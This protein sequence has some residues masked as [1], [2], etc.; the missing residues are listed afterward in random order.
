[1]TLMLSVSCAFGYTEVVDVTDV[2][3]SNNTATFSTNTSTSVTVALTLNVEAMKAIGGTTYSG[4]ATNLFKLNG[5]WENGNSG[6]IGVCNNGK[7]GSDSKNG[8][9]ADWFFSTSSKKND[10]SMN[11]DD[12]FSASTTAVDWSKV[13]NMTLVMTYKEGTESGNTVN[14]MLYSTS[15]SY[16]F[17]DGTTKTIGEE[18]NELY[19]FTQGVKVNA[20]TATSIDVNSDYVDSYTIYSDYLTIDQAKSLSATRVIPEP[21]TASLSLLAL[22]GLAARRRRR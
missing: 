9:Y 3:S 12:C 19:R 7:N 6:Y 13:V 2:T 10:S 5:I 17:D 4:T 8:L 15:F 22:A 20:F 14:H 1:M 18:Q 21:T 11:L 16:L